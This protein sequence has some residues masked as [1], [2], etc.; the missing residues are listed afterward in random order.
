MYSAFVRSAAGDA[1]VK[2]INRVL[3]DFTGNLHPVAAVAWRTLLQVTKIECGVTDG[4]V[5]G[6][7]AVLRFVQLRLKS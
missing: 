3:R 4:E 7:Q 5:F 6:R 1:R 2:T